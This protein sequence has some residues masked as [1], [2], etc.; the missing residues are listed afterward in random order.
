[1]IACQTVNPLRARWDDSIYLK[2]MVV[3]LIDGYATVSIRVL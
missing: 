1:L 2:L 3:A